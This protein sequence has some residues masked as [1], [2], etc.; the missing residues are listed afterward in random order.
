MESFKE[1][2]SVKYTV[3]ASDDYNEMARLR[4]SLLDKFPEAFVVAFR[5]GEKMDI[6]EAIRMFRENN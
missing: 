2:G 6:N 4:R 3:G 5:G 1:G